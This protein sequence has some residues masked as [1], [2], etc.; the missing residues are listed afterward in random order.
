MNIEKIRLCAFADEADPSLDGQIEA[1]KANGISLLEIRGVDGKN[2]STVTPE[3]AKEI[4]K[5]LDDNGISVWLI[6]K[7][8]NEQTHF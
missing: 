4:K 1:L 2:I 6:K 7:L 5:K 3:E 8:N